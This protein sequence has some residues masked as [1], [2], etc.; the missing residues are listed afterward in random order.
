M[1]NHS[2][3]PSLLP[4]TSPLRRGNPARE[5]LEKLL[6]ERRFEE[7]LD[8]VRVMEPSSPED[9][10]VLTRCV[11]LLEERLL[12][13]YRRTLDPSSVARVVAPPDDPA[14]L[15]IDDGGRAL[16]ERVDGRTTFEEL[17]R[18]WAG[19]VCDGYRGL[20]ALVHAGILAVSAPRRLSQND[21]TALLPVSR[22]RTLPPL[23]PRRTRHKQGPLGL[24]LGL[25]LV[26]G[27]VAAA[28]VAALPPEPPVSRTQ[29]AATGS[30]SVPASPTPAPAGAG[31]VTDGAEHAERDRDRVIDRASRA[32]LVPTSSR[33]RPAEAKLSIS[34]L[35][36][37]G[38]LR[39]VAIESAVT[40]RLGAFEAC[41][42][43]AGRH[44]G[45][46][47]VVMVVDGRGRV[48]QAAVGGTLPAPTRR[49]LR[50][51]LLR[52]RLPG[53]SG[54]ATFALTLSR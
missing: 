9:A 27:A 32:T 16:L 44:R 26:L 39:T 42:A 49:C 45:E 31:E 41:L 47:R 19:G 12:R 51:A 36:V 1:T 48:T 46:S 33:P 34:G 8:H 52:A 13:R 37:H 40:R 14:W 11:T 2:H 28:G 50:E 53:S 20:V 38:G 6:A 25:S 22:T 54:R 29:I 3:S 23:S 17:A 30:V 35:S 21:A 10:E 15:R 7:A 18:G 4:P 24:V 5:A 43:R